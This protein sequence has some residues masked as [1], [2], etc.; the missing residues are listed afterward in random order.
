MVMPGLRVL[1][2]LIRSI[3]LTFIVNAGILAAVPNRLNPF[4]QV[5][6][7]NLEDRNKDWHVWVRLN[8]FNQV[9]SFN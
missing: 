8:P 1:I 6:S 4:N 9:N 2:P 5:N 3:V 7:F